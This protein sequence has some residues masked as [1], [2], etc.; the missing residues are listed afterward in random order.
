[1]NDAIMN[2]EQVRQLA[3]DGFL[4]IGVVLLLA[5]EMPL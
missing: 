5:V 1:M 2:Y 3:I 4:L